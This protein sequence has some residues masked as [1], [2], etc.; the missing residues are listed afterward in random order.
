MQGHHG[1]FEPGKAQYSTPNFLTGCFLK[2]H[3]ETQNL[4]KAQSYLG[5]LASRGAPG[6]VRLVSSS[7][8]ISF[9]S[10]SARD[11]VVS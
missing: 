8:S 6:V 2:Q 3:I 11:D 10:C 5:G 1:E 9:F 7:E 4:G